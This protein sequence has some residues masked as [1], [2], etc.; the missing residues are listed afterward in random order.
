MSNR[1]FYLLPRPFMSDVVIIFWMPD[2]PVLVFIN[3]ERQWLVHNIPAVSQTLGNVLWHH[4][5]P[6]EY[7]QMA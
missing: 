2:K 3:V 4:H 5:Q 7:L 1:V 6:V